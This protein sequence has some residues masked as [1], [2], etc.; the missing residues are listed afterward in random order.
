M[1]I[2]KSKEGTQTNYSDTFISQIT[3]HIE[4]KFTKNKSVT[5]FDKIKNIFKTQFDLNKTSNFLKKLGLFSEINEVD[6][7]FYLKEKKA[8]ISF[9]SQ[10]TVQNTFE[11][12]A[13]LSLPNV[14][15]TG[16]SVNFECVPLKGIN[17]SF[18][19]PLISAQ[20]L[21]FFELKV[22]QEIR[23]I[24]EKKYGVRGINLIKQNENYS[25]GL[26]SD[27]F[28]KEIVYSSYLNYRDD[29]FNLHLNGGMNNF[30]PFFK[31]TAGIKGEF[32]WK[33]L[34]LKTNFQ[35][36]A[37]KGHAHPTN[38]YSLGG[39]TIGYKDN[40]INVNNGGKSFC[41]FNNEVGMK[42]GKVNLFIRNNVA[43]NS[44]KNKVAEIVRDIRQ[45]VPKLKEN[46]G[47]GLGIGFSYLF[48]GVNIGIAYTM[49]LKGDNKYVLI[50]DAEL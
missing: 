12:T 29:I 19:K 18:K 16:E 38:K 27:I 10:L 11:N 5:L 25:L 31:V 3:N 26:S 20:N 4:T 49:P 34:Y 36:G 33:K 13:T 21:T 40:S 42:L 14:Y 23:K 44:S 7:N 6:G 17:L 32:S 43:I 8:N 41:E 46:V 45:S 2:I 15:G 22:F 30:R 35:C 37:I 1:I 9:K 50:F 24:N 47:V 28:K 39:N 48:N